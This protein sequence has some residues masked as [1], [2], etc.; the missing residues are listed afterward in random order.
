MKVTKLSTPN[1]EVILQ[2]DHTIL[3]QFSHLKYGFFVIIGFDMML[4]GSFCFVF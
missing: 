1:V 2:S 4:A 3:K